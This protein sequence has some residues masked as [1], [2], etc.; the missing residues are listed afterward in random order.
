MAEIPPGAEINPKFFEGL[1]DWADYDMLQPYE[2][3]KK[4]WILVK[5]ENLSIGEVCFSFSQD[6]EELVN[7]WVKFEQILIVRSLHNPQ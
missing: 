5:D 7:C 3:K 4:F 2:G 6:Y 1:S